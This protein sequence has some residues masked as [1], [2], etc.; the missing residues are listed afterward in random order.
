MD[1]KSAPRIKQTIG[2]DKVARAMKDLTSYALAHFDFSDEDTAIIG[3]QSRGVVIANRLAFNIKREK[4]IDAATGAIDITLYRDDFSTK[5]IHPEIGETHLDFDIDNKKIVLIDD[6]LFTGRT[7]RAAI[8]Q[9]MDYGRPKSIHLLVL[10][11]RG[12]R[13]LPIQP[14]FAALKMET[15]RFESVN[16]RLEEIDE[17]DEI[18]VCDPVDE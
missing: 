4:N 13:E 18:V 1:M 15:E 10:I 7:I 8:D 9:L 14:E 12:H 3:I 11:D 5:G 16:L 2:A 17:K 6:V